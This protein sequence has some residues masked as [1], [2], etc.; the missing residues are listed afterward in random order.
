MLRACWLLCREDGEETSYL[1]TMTKSSFEDGLDL[2]RL[3]A[4]LDQDGRVLEVGCLLQPPLQDRAH[5]GA[6]LM[7]GA[8]L[9]VLTEGKD[10][11]PT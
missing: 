8:A 1:I 5:Y 7:P 6:T 3:A 10:L 2:R 9:C 11:V 4:R